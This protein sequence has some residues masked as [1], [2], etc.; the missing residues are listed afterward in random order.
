MSAQ[1]IPAGLHDDNS[2]FHYALR[3]DAQD[4]PISCSKRNKN[5]SHLMVG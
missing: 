5:I 1:A 3:F 2:K 4:A